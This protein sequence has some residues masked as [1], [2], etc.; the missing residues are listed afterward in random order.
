[1]S[2]LVS[3]GKYPVLG[4]FEIALAVLASAD[5]HHNPNMIFMNLVM[6]TTISV[7]S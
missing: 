1:M 2:I 7:Y 4:S 3:N 5:G 6:G